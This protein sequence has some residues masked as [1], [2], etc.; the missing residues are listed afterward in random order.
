MCFKRF[1]TISHGIDGTLEYDFNM[2]SY[3]YF[4][5]EISLNAVNRTLF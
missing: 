3:L 1:N 5:T 4:Y 2:N